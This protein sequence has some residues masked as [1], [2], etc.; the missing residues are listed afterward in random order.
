MKRTSCS[1]A[2]TGW[3]VVSCGSPEN[4]SE[5]ESVGDETGVATGSD[6]G[7]GDSGSG[8]ATEDGTE[9][10]D[11]SDSGGP[12]GSSTGEDADDC[13]SPGIE[14]L[15]QCPEGLQPVGTPGGQTVDQFAF[16]WE[17]FDD[18]C[19]I[20]WPAP[21]YFL[22][23]DDII[24]LSL[25]VEADAPLVYL[26]G[27]ANE[28]TVLVDLAT[29][30]DTGLGEPPLKHAPATT[31][32]LTLPLNDETVPAPGCLAV[33]PMVEGD[34]TGGGGLIHIATRRGEPEAGSGQLI[35]NAVRV[36]NV[37]I[38]EAEI[39]SALLGAHNLYALNGAGTL[40]DINYVDLAT[41]NGPF[42]PIEGAEVDALRSSDTGGSGSSINVFFI[43][44]FTDASGVLGIAA[45]VPGPNGVQGTAGSGVVV[46]TDSHR[47]VDGAV[48]TGLMSETIAHEL[49]HQ[50][51]LFHTTED[52]GSDHDVIPD[53][54][55]CTLDM[56]ADQDGV[57]S[58]EECP[59]G[60]NVMFWTSGT[61]SQDVMSLVQSDVLFFSPVST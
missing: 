27:V 56:D 31:A 5:P 4:E 9:G 1:L 38:T 40:T 3:L 50:L 34:A 23:P 6:S 22:L 17:V 20:T 55:E 29:R 42:I 26:A 16:D 53:T 37:Q 28:G 58:A 13:G 33:L 35:V 21:Q 18:E 60:D 24:S 10:A 19:G 61:F 12:A 11:S 2:V 52:D 30:G 48:Q 7:E 57:L 46:A 15:L 32:N 8:S 39:E 44:D 45:G 14:T 25:V 43:D 47:D 41:D 59:D 36:D 51:G 49:G 54:P